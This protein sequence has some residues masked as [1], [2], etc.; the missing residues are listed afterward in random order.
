[1]GSSILSRSAVVYI[2]AP[3]LAFFFPHLFLVVGGY[4][5]WIMPVPREIGFVENATALFFVIGG[6]YAFVL[7]KND[8]SKNVSLLRPALVIYGI[9]AIFVALEEVSYGQQ[10]VHFNSPEWFL[11]NNFNKEVNLHN[12]GADSLSHVMKTG[13]YLVASLFGIIAPLAVLYG[14]VKI[15][16][17]NIISYIIPTAWMIV[18]SLFHLFANLPKT[19]LKVL[20]SG[21]AMVDASQYFNESGE[22][23]EYMLGVWVILFLVSAHRALVRD[24][25]VFAGVKN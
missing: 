1:M 16:K 3:A 22:Y 11:E 18:P 10:F 2:G 14:A 6:V 9:L 25:G 19:I 12:L 7:A 21:Q 13:G 8:L 4:Y 15:P 17:G 20:P 24:Y 5:D 23:E